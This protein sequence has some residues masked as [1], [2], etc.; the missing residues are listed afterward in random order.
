[1]F[2]MST[3]AFVLYWSSSPA[4][5]GW[6]CEPDFSA[7]TLQDPQPPGGPEA[8]QGRKHTQHEPPA[9]DEDRSERRPD[10]AKHERWREFR[11]GRMPTPSPEMIE[12]AMGVLQEKLPQYYQ[13]MTKLRTD[14]K[15]KFERAIGR[16]MP[17][18]MEYLE[19]RDRGDQ[20]LADTII[21][22]F[23]IEHQLRKLSRDFKAAEGSLEKQATCE[24]QIRDLVR[25]QLE[26]RMLRQ[27][28]RL[29]EFAE[30]LERQRKD[31]ESERQSL[32]Q[33]RA[34]LD[35]LVAGRV[36]E[37]KSGKM[38]ERFHPRGPRHGGAGELEGPPRGAHGQG[39]RPPSDHPHGDSTD[40]RSP[41]RESEPGASPPAPA[42]PQPP[43]NEDRPKE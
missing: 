8:D 22:E 43:N 15:A 25:R 18:A 28:A 35:E 42:A 31:L 1:M 4:G 24:Q 20:K 6:F 39:P 5:A 2:A 14:D 16:I 30:R 19:L 33:R 9:V 7:V 13:E 38:G 23:K 10:R 29:K 34:K 17:V 41:D 36:E 40:P 37:V 26:I 32:E 27:E 12:M 3:L 21:E 11:E